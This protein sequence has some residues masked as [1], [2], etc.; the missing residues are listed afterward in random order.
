[1]RLN[2]VTNELFRSAIRDFEMGGVRVPAGASIS[3]PMATVTA[4]D[5]RWAGK[6]GEMDPNVFNPERMLT[7]EG[8][9]PGDQMPFGHGGRHC[10]G[11]HLAMAEM[12]AFLALMGQ[13]YRIE[14]DTN[15]EWQYGVGRV[16]K[17]GLPMVVTRL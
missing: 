8:L 3:L 11:V 15:T 1:M 9:K 5:P 10:L 6:T 13:G 7:P 14:A 4:S 17:N 16:P 2:P 12:K